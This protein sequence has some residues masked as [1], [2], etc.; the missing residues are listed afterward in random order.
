MAEENPHIEIKQLPKPIDNPREQY[1][2]ENENLIIGPPGFIFRIY[3]TLEERLQ[4]SLKEQKEYNFNASKL[5]RN[6]SLGRLVEKNMFNNTTNNK[7]LRRNNSQLIKNNT[8]TTNLHQPILRFKNRTDLERICDT[9]QQYVK[10]SEQESIKEIRDRHVH[11]IDFPTGILFKGGFKDM[12]NLQKLQKDKKKFESTLNKLNLK[13]TLK[14]NN[15]NYQS[16]DD[17]KNFET[18]E[19]NKPK[20]F[21]TRLQRLNVEA[22]K[23]R[24]NLHL[25]THFKGVESVFI[26][27]NQISKTIKKEENLSQ[28]N[29]G[30]YAYNDKSEKEEIE[31]RNEYKE[32]IENLLLEEKEKEKLINTKQFSQYLNNKKFF[33]DIVKKNTDNNK[34]N[35]EIKIN[36]IKKMNYLKKLA[37]KDNFKSSNL[38][39]ENMNGNNNTENSSNEDN[40]KNKKNQQFENDHTLRIGGKIYNIESQIGQIAKAI[41]NKCKFYPIKKEEGK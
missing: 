25:K 26:N 2:F 33:N 20:I 37:F 9:I 16:E 4:E 40:G 24:S 5:S 7:F 3:P 8:Q 28:K 31:K 41:L 34:E 27:P 6:N 15:K 14:D 19:K 29:I 13:N 22:K 11:S 23:I 36:Q 21:F 38:I 12:Q 32:D 35:E 1:L 30:N 18:T 17:T 39:H 10:P